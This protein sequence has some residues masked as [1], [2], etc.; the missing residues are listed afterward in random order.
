MA[1]GKA[2]SPSHSSHLPGP[3]GCCRISQW[4]SAKV[5]MKLA[6]MLRYPDLMIDMQSLPDT[7]IAQTVHDAGAS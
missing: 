7:R 2:Y 1:L 6:Q 5:A 3:Y 4:T